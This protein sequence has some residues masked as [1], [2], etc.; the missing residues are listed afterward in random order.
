MVGMVGYRR[1]A[2]PVPGLHEHSGWARRKV[3][4]NIGQNRLKS[5][6]F[7]RKRTIYKPKM[8]KYPQRPFM[9]PALMRARHKLPRLWFN[10][11]GRSSLT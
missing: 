1:V 2:N 6:Q 9:E 7:G 11:L 4:T 10:S 8:V 5:G 3:F